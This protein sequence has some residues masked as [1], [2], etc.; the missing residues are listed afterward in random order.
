MPLSFYCI[1]MAPV[2][3]LLRNNNAGE[4][5]LHVVC[6]CGALFDSIQSSLIDH[7][8][9]VVKSVRT[10]QGDLPLFLACETAKTFLDTNFILIF[11]LIAI[12]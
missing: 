8:P 10:S 11:I 4:T 5:P 1:V 9:V 3:I 12:P 7:S 6:C 2:N